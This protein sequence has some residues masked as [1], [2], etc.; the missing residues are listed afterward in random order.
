MNDRSKA[1]SG[2]SA[3]ARYWRAP[4][5]QPYVV[6][7]LDRKMAELSR[8]LS[9]VEKAT[10]RVLAEYPA[11]GDFGLLG[12]AATRLA[13]LQARG[14]LPRMSGR[15]I[16]Q[17]LQL[18]FWPEHPAPVSALNGWWLLYELDRT[19]RAVVTLAADPTSDD[20]MRFRKCRLSQRLAELKVSE[21]GQGRLR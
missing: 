19:E 20:P 3:L 10:I 7:P 21:R 16:T 11:A 12:E 14:I 18:V 8:R 5:V 9:T 13:H 1:T 2:V 17:H 15:D 6:V 4:N